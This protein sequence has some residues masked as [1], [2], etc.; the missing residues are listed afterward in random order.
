MKTFS[1]NLFHLRLVS[2]F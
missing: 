2:E 1:S